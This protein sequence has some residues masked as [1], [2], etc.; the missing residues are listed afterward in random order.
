[1]GDKEAPKKSSRR[2]AKEFPWLAAVGMTAKKR[3]YADGPWTFTGRI[4]VPDG[5]NISSHKGR[6]SRRHPPIPLELVITREQ[7]A[8]LHSFAMDNPEIFL[9]TLLVDFFSPALAASEASRSRTGR[10]SALETPLHWL[11]R[12]ACEVYHLFKHLIS[13][14][15]R[16]S[17][18]R[19]FLSV[20]PN[21]HTDFLYLDGP[22]GGKFDPKALTAFYLEGSLRYR[23]YD[24]AQIGIRSFMERIEST[25]TEFSDGLYLHTILSMKPENDYSKMTDAELEK[26]VERPYFVLLKW[27]TPRNETDPHDETNMAGNADGEAGYMSPFFKSFWES[28]FHKKPYPA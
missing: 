12:E 14:G 15:K 22:L 28:L 2:R 7:L 10:Y 27:M 26:I 16:P 20:L 8:R 17:Y 6:S 19:A 3:R 18:F 11:N 24:P 21:D 4:T 9:H 23:G 13:S 1:M 25:A 5:I